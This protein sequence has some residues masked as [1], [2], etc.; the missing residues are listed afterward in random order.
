MSDMRRLL[1]DPT[2]S[3]ETRELVG[4]LEVP[5][6]LGGST[7]SAIGLRVAKSLALPVAAGTFLSL[8]TTA[9]WAAI[10]AGGALAVSLVVVATSEP[11]PPKGPSVNAPAAA[12]VPAPPAKRALAPA[13]LEKPAVVEE[14]PDAKDPAPSR[15][16]SRRDTLKLEESLLEQARRSIDS[17]SRALSLL[18]EHERRFP[19]GELTAERLYLTAQTQARA[20]NGTAARHYARLLAERFPKSTYVRRVRPLLDAPS[21]PTPSTSAR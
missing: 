3:D 21:A 1:D 20:G 13:E 5:A 16:A 17:P 15:G 9:A 11:E 8:K 18:R 12:P 6:P 10:V 2:V 4:S 14:A 19:N 7:R